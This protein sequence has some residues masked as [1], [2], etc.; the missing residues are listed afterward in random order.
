[1]RCLSLVLALLVPFSAFAQSDPAEDARAAR[2]LLERAAERLDTST[3]AR[4]RVRALTETVQAYEAGLSALRSGIRAADREQSDLAAALQGR[5]VEI[6]ALVA[7]LM[8]LG[9]EPSPVIFLHPAGA[10]GSA[11]AA[12]LL[13]DVTPV[14]NDEAAQLRDELMRIQTL[15]ALQAEALSRLEAG[16]AEVQEARSALN[17][18]IAERTDLPTRF[19]N[20]PVREAI[21][22]ASSDTLAH[23]ADGLDRVAVARKSATPAR[24][25]EE[26]GSLSY[27]VQ[28]VVLRR[29]GEADA[30]GVARPGILMAT[31]PK[32]LV[33]SPTS[34]TIRYTGP[35]LDLGEVVILEPQARVLFILAG[36]DRVYG[37]AGEVIDAGSPL[38]LMGGEEPENSSASSLDGDDTGGDLT[39]T[40]YIEVRQDNSPED[41]SL[42]FRTDKDG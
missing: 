17:Q 27:P 18:A 15:Q 36:L 40:L 7:A 16:M 3:S 33:T 30:A 1:M 13:S 35:L 22:V 24:L 26:K 34:A 9:E 12:M 31:R 11:R 28:G 29:S 37:V 20:D 4:D 23:F 14:L 21:L 25:A 5:D 8:R 32:A 10:V 19:T 42:W 39:E 38:G 41:P 6:A 2:V